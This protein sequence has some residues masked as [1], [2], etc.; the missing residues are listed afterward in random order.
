MEFR[1]SELAARLG[2]TLRGDD[3]VVTGVGTLESAGPDDI[4]FLADAK[5][6]ALLDTTRAAAVVVDEAHAAGVGRALVSANPYMDFAR[7][8]FLFTPAQGCLEGTGVHERAFVHPG[9]EV[10]P[11]ADIYPF[12]FV[13]DGAKIGPRTR[14]FPGCYVG[15]GC[16]IGE[17]C[18]LYPNVSLMA[19][20]VLGNR[21]MIHPGAVLGADGFG[22]VPTDDGRQK[23]PQVGRV[24]VE[25]DVEIGANTAIDRAML[26][27]TVIGHG[28]KID[29]LVQIA[30][31]CILGEHCTIVSQVGIAGSTKVGRGVIM[32]GQ[33]GVADHVT[34]GNDAI[35]GPQCGVR[36]DVEEGRRMGGHP[37]MDYGTYMRN[38][39]LAPKIPDL[40]KR[41]KAL[42]KE[43][44][45]LVTKRT[46]EDNE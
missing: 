28:T 8:L 1:L 46:G 40:F 17:D 34:I 32:A 12:A 39:S 44:A 14:V 38:M 42:E 25:D 18:T 16:V 9:A 26:D 27:R 6:A 11:T 15:E 31:N 35:I 29:N 30:H 19:G 43:L 2:L 4:T 21:V 10:D 13:A 22:Y 33:A 3:C 23:I 37:A 41:V 24:V 45:A 20:T 7:I 5:Y 36:T